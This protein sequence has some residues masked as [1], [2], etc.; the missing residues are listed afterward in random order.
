MNKRIYGF[1]MIRIYACLAV[2]MI[3]V[4]AIYVKQDVNSSA[5]VIGNIFDSISRCGVPLFL[6]LSGALMLN[7]KK[8]KTIKQMIQTSISMIG[9]LLFWSSLYAIIYQFVIHQNEVSVVSL[10][11][12]IL[13]G[14]YH[15]WY[16]YVMV[17]LYLITPILK[18]I[19]KKEHQQLIKYLLGLAIIFTFV[20]PLINYFFQIFVES[21]SITKLINKVHFEMIGSYLT[22]Y[23]LGWYVTN[24]EV[25]YKKTIYA[26]GVV[27]II[28]TII[29]TQITKNYD[30]FYD[31]SL[32]TILLLSLA[33]FMFIFDFSKRLKLKET[34]IKLLSILSKLTFGV[35]L[36]H[37]LV[38]Y[39]ISKYVIISHV[40]IECIVIFI[41]TVVISFVISFILS[42]IGY[43]KKLIKC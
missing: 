16:L 12:T 10:I 24:F 27:S 26:L 41:L 22:Y 5:F 38:L 40:L 43:L 30:F 17:G 36:I 37:I 1:D 33:I 3:H 4:S 21:I 39:Y 35:Y 28:F 20:I 8:E 15:M 31:T 14:H 32:I 7:E 19:I 6:M 9:I 42:K 25:K 18:V 34:T 29:M 23:I 2:V 11:K 13:F